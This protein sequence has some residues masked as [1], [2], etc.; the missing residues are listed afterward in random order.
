MV[1]GMGKLGI[2]Y[3]HGADGMGSRVLPVHFS[4]CNPDQDDAHCHHNNKRYQGETA[5]LKSSSIFPD[6]PALFRL[7]LYTDI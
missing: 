4:G 3:V 2:G 6:S 7:L 5:G 1:M